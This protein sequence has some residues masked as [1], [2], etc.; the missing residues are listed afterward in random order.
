M[1][2]AFLTE[3]WLVAG[4]RVRQTVTF[5]GLGTSQLGAPILPL[6]FQAELS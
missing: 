1:K 5:W 3:L 2:P 4:V 6:T